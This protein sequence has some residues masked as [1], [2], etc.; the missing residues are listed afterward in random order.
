MLAAPAHGFVFLAAP[1]TGSTSI[2]LAFADHAQLITNRPP[3]LKHVTAIG[4]D[5][6]FAPILTRHGFERTSYVT[7]SLIREPIDL[8]LSWYR[9]RSRR[10]IRGRPRYTGDLSFDAFAEQIAAGEADFRP[11]GKFYCSKDGTLLV[12]RLYR[13]DHLDACVDWMSERVGASVEVGRVNASP[14]REVTVSAFARR[15][16]EDVLAVD[17]ELYHGAL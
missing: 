15:T 17:L 2:Q 7:T 8:T 11:G 14:Q 10:A 9:Y 3:S 16:L 6:D 1:K 12:E 4:F 5:R 13:Y